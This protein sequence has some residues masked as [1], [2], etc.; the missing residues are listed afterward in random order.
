M[1]WVQTLYETYER[2]APAFAQG[3][4]AL[5][6]IG[7]TKQQAHLEIILDGQGNFKRAQVVAKENTLVPATERSAGRT[8]GEAPH[9]LCDKIQ[10]CA[11]DY[12][13]FH[14]RKDA[15]FDSYLKQLTDWCAS[16][17]AHPKAKAV[18]AY[19]SQKRVVADLVE[20]KILWLDEQRHLRTA[21]PPEQPEAALFKMLTPKKEK[22]SDA[23]LRDQGD[24][25]V[26]WRVE[27]PGEH[28]TGTWEDKSLLQS[29]T[30]YYASQQ[31]KTGICLVTGE[32]TIL[33]E[34][35]PAKLRHGA[36]K[37]KLISS[38]DTSG[39]TYRGEHFT[40]AEQ[41]AGVG[42]AVTQKAHNALR[43][44]IDR[45]GAKNGEQVIVAWAIAG[46]PIPNPLEDTH[47]L[48]AAAMREVGV[49]LPDSVPKA[50]TEGNAN[51][52][53]DL[54]LR[55]K[56]LVAGYHAKLGDTDN[57]V[58]MGL[59]SA[60]PGRMAITYYR[61][62][63]G[64]EFLER[65]EHWHK[66]IAWHLTGYDK[67]ANTAI[68][69]TGAPAP[70][71]IAEAAFGRRLDD[72]LK[73]ATVERLLPCIID[74]QPLPRDLVHST[75]RRASNRVGLDDW[76][77]E[78]TLGIACALYRKQA[79]ENQHK[80]ED[81]AMSLEP[82]RTDR[83]YLY[84]RLL[85]IADNLESAALELA[86]E[87]RDTTATRLMTR[88]ADRPFSTWPVIHEALNRAYMPRLQASSKEL[89]HGILSRDKRL[90]GEIKDLFR[91]DDFKKDTKLSGEFLLGFYCQRQA[92]WAKKDAP[93][94]ASPDEDQAE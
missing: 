36:D 64:S 12:K 47:N 16:D 40:D 26:R 61:E 88:F 93:E 51:T 44:L 49:T 3:D 23:P 92:L 53:Q 63:T 9:P 7:H 11:G 68:R 62:L 33:A 22:G 27:V 42:F 37:A 79:N 84:G 29:W 17:Q 54:A 75:V 31:T 14:G 67:E 45:Q 2:C 35:H 19:V 48:W 89:Y 10:Y 71:D 90:I 24:A 25:F 66:S 34:Q 8:S 30:D 57:V 59:D 76:E 85:A 77:W 72:K 70:R 69:F 65:I 74:G 94:A 38:N 87:K 78:K 39:F 50:Q 60:T 81:Y 86:H 82:N 18:L 80:K 1:S 46:N 58:V 5:T 83:D 13:V 41:A 20:A 56:R 32:D 15:Y 73:K 55:L 4:D 91:P 21:P 43:W 52:A 6:P 28:A